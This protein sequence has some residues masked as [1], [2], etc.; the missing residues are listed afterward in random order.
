MA[1]GVR[2]G[3]YTYTINLRTSA[4]RLF[5]HDRDPYELENVV[6]HPEYRE[7]VTELRARTATLSTC[8]GASCRRSFPALPP[9][10][11]PH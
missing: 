2:T 11:A 10:A 8:A 3:R 6:G 5:N 4:E 7:V 9:I 1:R